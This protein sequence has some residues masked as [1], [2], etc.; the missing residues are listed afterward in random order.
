MFCAKFVCRAESTE[1]LLPLLAAPLLVTNAS[2]ITCNGQLQL[3]ITSLSTC[4]LRHTMTPMPTPAAPLSTL[5]AGEAPPPVRTNVRAALQAVAAHSAACPQAVPLEL[6]VRLRSW[7]MV[8]PSCRSAVDVGRVLQS[9]LLCSELFQVCAVLPGECVVALLLGERA[10]PRGVILTAIDSLR[11]VV[12][13]NCVSRLV[14]R[15]S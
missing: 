9:Q 10:R 3:S 4:L 8:L 14:S 12:L 15:P 13:L 1:A 2:V 7:H 6:C 5:P 11:P